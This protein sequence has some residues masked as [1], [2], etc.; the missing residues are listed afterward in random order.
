M[1]RGRARARLRLG[2]LRFYGARTPRARGLDARPDR[3]HGR[4][5]R[6]GTTPS[7]STSPATTGCERL[8]LDAEHE[9]G[10][11]RDQ[12][13]FGE[14]ITIEDNMA[15]LVALPIRRDA[16]LLAQRARPVGGLPRRRSTARRDGSSSRSSSADVLPAG[17][18][19]VVGRPAVDPSAAP[20]SPEEANP[21]PAG[22]RLLVQ[23]HWE[24]ARELEIA[25]DAG[26]HG[27][28]DAQL[29]EDLFRPGAA[30]DPLGRRAGYTDGLLSLA[31]GLAANES[32][33]AGRMVAVDE[34]ALTRP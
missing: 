32:L 26:A 13:V 19:G 1:A 14:G 8:Y 29:L 24:M 6:R 27:G 18:A 21:R 16:H 11:I 12:D 9:D 28:G 15:V 23:R 31:V 3:V 30:A 10:Y 25:E 34:L 20:G 4:A 17:A 22:A 7:P 2:G 33:R 5:R